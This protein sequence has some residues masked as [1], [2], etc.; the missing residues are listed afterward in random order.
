[1]TIKSILNIENNRTENEYN[2]IHLFRE[3]KWWSA[4]QLHPP[5]GGCLGKGC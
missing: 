3:G 5:K 2:L 1:M 4:C